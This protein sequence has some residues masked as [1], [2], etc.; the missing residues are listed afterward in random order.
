MHT[1]HFL[2]LYCLYAFKNERTV[3]GTYHL[4]KGKKTS[5]TIQDARLFAVDFL[6]GIIPEM[7]RHTFEQDIASLSESGY[8]SIPQEGRTSLTEAG[9]QMLNDTLSRNPFPAGLN[10]WRFHASSGPFWQRFS[11]MVQALSHLRAGVRG[12]IPVAAKEEHQAW[13][14]QALPAGSRARHKYQENLYKEVVMQLEDH[15]SDLDAAIFTMRLSAKG[16]YGLTLKQISGK[17]G[18][19]EMEVRLRFLGTLHRI[20]QTASDYRDPYPL[21]YSF[22]PGQEDRLPLTKTARRTWEL[23]RAGKSI[24]EAAAIRRL[25]R[26]TIED[27][28]VE[29]ALNVPGFS[30]DRFIPANKKADIRRAIAAAETRKLRELKELAGDGADYF[31]IR[32]ILAKEEALHGSA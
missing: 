6:F 4:L 19:D 21:L 3:Y 11:L 15:S 1:R 9:E 29:L 26:S 23:I 28:V 13:V 24:E 27:H 7:D 22:I 30:I 20:I 14:K 17:L 25:K 31:E 8:L 2:I 16:S 5:Q 10:G 18:K 12:Y 32:L